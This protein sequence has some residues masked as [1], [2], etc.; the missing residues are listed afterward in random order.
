MGKRFYCSENICRDCGRPIEKNNGNKQLCYHCAEER[1]AS[2]KRTNYVDK[3]RWYNSE[4][5]E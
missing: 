5:E 1:R 2:Q 3:K 4:P